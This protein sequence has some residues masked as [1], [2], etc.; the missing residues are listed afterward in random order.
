MERHGIPTISHG[1]SQRHTAVGVC[2]MWVALEPVIYDRELQA[3]ARLRLMRAVMQ[4]ELFLGREEC[5]RWGTAD[6]T[7]ILGQRLVE[8]GR[9]MA[10]GALRES[11]ALPSESTLRSAYRL[12]GSLA[13][14]AA[15]TAPATQE[16]S[17]LN[18]FPVT[19]SRDV[20]AYSRYGCSETSEQELKYAVMLGF[21]PMD[22][23]LLLSS[24]GMAA[25]ALIEN[26]LLR[27]V[28]RAGDR[29]VLHP[30]VYFETQQQLRSL[31]F[32]DIH[33]AHG[34]GR[35]DILDA[36]VTIRPRV[37][38]VDP[39]T[40]SADFRAIDLRRLLQD[41]ARMCER[42]TWFVVD[43]TLLSGAFDPFSGPSHPNIRVL[44]YE[45][46]CKYLQFGLDL[47]PAGIVVVDTALAERFLQLRRGI[48]AI[49]SET[50][51]LPQATRA[52]YLNYL[53][54]QTACVLAIAGAVDAGCGGEERPISVVHP[55]LSGHPDRREVQHHVHLGG[56]LVFRFTREI[57][58][59]RKPLEAFIDLLMANARSQ[60][61]PLTSGVSFGFR[62][63]RICAAWSS[64]DADHAFL[65][66]SAGVDSGR[67]AELGKLIGECAVRFVMASSAP[68]N[69]RTGQE[70][71]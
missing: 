51:I 55:L 64:Y 22:S 46:G 14:L 47:G 1:A 60:C 28:I 24:S 26:F 21:D 52:A 8:E 27:D 59:R 34:S 11:A 49:T 16:S 2:G 9:R 36:I 67:A 41:A 71:L 50:L 3:D 35:E 31:E 56:I 32:L 13:N 30:G 37:V 62:V 39:L 38:F 66:L 6:P 25:Y 44:Y 7:W 45:S 15:W 5:A 61:L 53:N 70:C 58:N 18:S 65:R 42:E 48:G 63:P 12:I 17:A 33:V 29:I 4:M 20:V 19:A 10:R 54:A 69:A 40:N 43:G 23:R 68:S 57:L